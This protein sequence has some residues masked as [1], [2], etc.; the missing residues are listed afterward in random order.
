MGAPNKQATST[1]VLVLVLV[2][3]HNSVNFERLKCETAADQRASPLSWPWPLWNA[4]ANDIA[5]SGYRHVSYDSTIRNESHL[6][7]HPPSS[8]SF[9]QRASLQRLIV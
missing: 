7:R 8:C 3:V 2:L 1:H 6:T 5:R 9:H 4:L